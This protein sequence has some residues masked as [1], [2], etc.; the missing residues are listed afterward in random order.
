M[1]AAVV[2]LYVLWVSHLVAAIAGSSQRAPAEVEITG[3]KA[4]MRSF[5][6]HGDAPELTEAA[7]KETSGCM[8]GLYAFKDSLRS[9]GFNIPQNGEHIDTN[10]LAEVTEG[11]SSTDEFIF[12]NRLFHKEMQKHEGNERPAVICQTGFNYGTSAYAFL[13]STKA[14]LISWDLG[15]HPYV[16][17]ADRL[18]QADFPDRHQ[19]VLGDSR[20]TLQAAALGSGPLQ[21]EERC[22]AIFVDGGHDEKVTTADLENFAKLAAPGALLV[23]DDCHSD[24]QGFSSVN[25]AFTDFVKKGKATEISVLGPKFA[26]HRS[27]CVARYPDV[28]A[29]A[30]G[31][32]SQK[33]QANFSEGRRQRIKTPSPTDPREIQ[34]EAQVIWLSILVLGTLVTSLIIGWI[35][36]EKTQIQ[37][38]MKCYGG[39]FGEQ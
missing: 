35:I 19:L 23:V 1:I 33:I 32:L 15:E 28:P 17:V 11:G 12:L 26:F 27:V 38:L 21:R 9:S 31:I 18:L 34:Q 16:E 25:A 10:V 37:E 14:R 22:D 20:K 3:A 36:P 8:T 2:A 5:K 30:P 4:L 39:S 24:W 29:E 13:C 6:V 7:E